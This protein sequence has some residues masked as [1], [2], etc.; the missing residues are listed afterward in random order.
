ME[1]VAQDIVQVTTG[2]ISLVFIETPRFAVRLI[3]LL[4]TVWLVGKKTCEEHG[5]RRPTYFKSRFLDSR[6]VEPE[7]KQP[8]KLEPQE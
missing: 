5:T 7:A 8:I 1:T 3:L 6:P 2:V 4:P